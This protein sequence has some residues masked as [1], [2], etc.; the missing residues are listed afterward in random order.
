MKL[1]PLFLVFFLLASL[2]IYGQESDKYFVYE[3]DAQG[4]LKAEGWLQN[5]KKVDFWYFYYP[6]GQVAEEGHYINGKKTLFWYFYYPN[7]KLEKEGHYNGGNKVGYWY[8]YNKNGTVLKEG[9]YHNGIAEN[10]WIFYENQ[11]K[12]IYQYQNNKKHGYALRYKD[13]KLLKAEKYIEN[14]KV[15]EW[16]SIIAFKLDNP[17]VSLN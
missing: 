17:N 5:N 12:T 6:N 7:G 14:E 3:Y 4:N 15:G 11:Y 9:H 2:S 10:W 16:T 1:K 8:F 13:K